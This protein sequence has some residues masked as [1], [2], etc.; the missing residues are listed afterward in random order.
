MN[1]KTLTVLAVFVLLILINKPVLSEGAIGVSPSKLIVEV[2]Q[3]SR[4]EQKFILNRSFTDGEAKFTVRLDEDSPYI[5]LL[6]E[7]LILPDGAQET[8]YHFSIDATQANLGEQE[9]ILRFCLVPPEEQESQGVGINFC[10]GPK[11]I[12]T[13]VTPSNQHYE[14]INRVE[15]KMVLALFLIVVFSLAIFL[16]VKKRK[17]K[18]H[19]DKK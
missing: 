9:N 18:I 6:E 15:V 1:T 4:T 16:V 10:L 8:E 13:V 19:G 17:K 12:F 2:E 3:G 11:I 14:L 5:D 7:E